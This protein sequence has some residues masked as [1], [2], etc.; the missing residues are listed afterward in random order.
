MCKVVNVCL[1]AV[2]VSCTEPTPNYCDEN[3]DCETTHFCDMRT[4]SCQPR[5]DSGALDGGGGDDAA[6]KIAFG[7]TI[8]TS[9]GEDDVVAGWVD[10]TTG[11]LTVGTVGGGIVSDYGSEIVFGNTKTP[12]ILGKFGY[13]HGGHVGGGATF[14]ASTIVSGPGFLWYPACGLPVP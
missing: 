6:K 7:S 5:V 9:K 2:L 1:V 13:Y 14:G 12:Y 11:K 8:Y 3:A 10:D 4:N